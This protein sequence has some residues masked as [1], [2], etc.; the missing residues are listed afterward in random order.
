MEFVKEASEGI[1]PS[2]CPPTSSTSKDANINA[3]VKI[4]NPNPVTNERNV[5]TEN[6]V[7]VSSGAIDSKKGGM[8]RGICRYY[9]Q[10]RCTRGDTCVFSH[11]IPPDEIKPHGK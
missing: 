5:A 6:V 1:P 11:N 2:T 10:G 8:E 4:E 3:Q 7:A 9:R